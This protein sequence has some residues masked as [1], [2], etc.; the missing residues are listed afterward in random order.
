MVPLVW[1]YQMV[2]E[3]VLEIMLYLYT[4][5]HWYGIAFSTTLFNYGMHD[6]AIGTKRY[7]G[8]YVRVLEYAGLWCT[9]TWYHCG[10][11]QG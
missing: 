7:G 4:V 6:G 1:Q 5:Y 3:Y 2:L 9:Y 11:Y 8:T 10:T